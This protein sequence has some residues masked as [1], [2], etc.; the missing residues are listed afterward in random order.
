MERKWRK[1]KNFREAN[2]QE[3]EEK[4]P[5]QN[6]PQTKAGKIILRSTKEMQTLNTNLIYVYMNVFCQ[7]LGSG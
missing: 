6:P 1:T 7:E 3:Y 5:E 4:Y 2:K